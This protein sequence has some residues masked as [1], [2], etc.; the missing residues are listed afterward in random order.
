M[1]KLFTSSVSNSEVTNSSRIQIEKYIQFEANFEFLMRYLKLKNSRV[2]NKPKN[3][4]ILIVKY[5]NIFH[6]HKH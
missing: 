5:G 1:T 2:I 4:S 6:I 3:N